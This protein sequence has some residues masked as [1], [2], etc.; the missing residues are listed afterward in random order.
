M[1]D[2]RT[3][4]YIALLIGIPVLLI[5]VDIGIGEYQIRRMAKSNNEFYQFIDE[6][7][8][9]HE[10][11]YSTPPWVFPEWVDLEGQ[12]YEYQDGTGE[13]K[14]GY[15]NGRKVVMREG[16]GRMITAP[17]WNYDVWVMP[18]GEIGLFAPDSEPL[19]KSVTLDG[20]TYTLC[21]KLTLRQY[22]MYLEGIPLYK[23]IG[24]N[25]INA[26]IRQPKKRDK[27]D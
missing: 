26:V 6:C 20:K 15:L 4:I 25:D 17:Q 9:R 1:S 16:T 14:T 18:N 2:K 10:D 13:K 22:Q 7:D 24:E 27:E 8:K 19:Y 3:R 5:A 12:Y 23:L 21:H 11:R